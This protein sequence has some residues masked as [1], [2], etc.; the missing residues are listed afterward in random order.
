MDRAWSLLRN[1]QPGNPVPADMYVLDYRDRERPR[2]TVEEREEFPDT[3]GIRLVLVDPDNGADD[4]FDDGVR[5]AVTVLSFATGRTLR[6]R[7]H[8]LGHPFGNTLCDL[9]QQRRAFE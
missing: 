2:W 6:S 4:L 1:L 8:R 9:D 3:A 5:A 7:P